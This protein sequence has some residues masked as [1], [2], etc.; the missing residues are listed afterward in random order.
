M[1]NIT[2]TILTSTVKAAA[3]RRSDTVIMLIICTMVISTTRMVIMLMSMCYRL[4]KK[5][6]IDAI[7]SLKAMMQNINTALT[8]VTSRC[9]MVITLIILLMA[10]CIIRMVTTVMTTDRLKW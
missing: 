5:I 10:D 8:V 2:K 4:V 7:L 9:H 3:I 1:K 6:P